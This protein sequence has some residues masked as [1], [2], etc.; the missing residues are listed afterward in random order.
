MRRGIRWPKPRVE[1]GNEAIISS[2]AQ[3][4]RSFNSKPVKKPTWTGGMFWPA[5]LV[6][7]GQGAFRFDMLHDGVSDVWAEDDHGR[8]GWVQNV[9]IGTSGVRV[10][11]RPRD[12]MVKLDGRVVDE[13]GKGM[14]GTVTLCRTDNNQPSELVDGAVGEDGSF[15][16]EAK[17]PSPTDFQF[18]RLVFVSDSGRTAWRT[19]PKNSGTV[20]LQLQP[21]AKVSGVVTD[22][23]GAPLAGAKVQLYSGKQIAYG[24]LI[25]DKVLR[26][27]LP[28]ATTD[29]A[30]RFTLGGLPADADVSVIANKDGY[31]YENAWWLK[32]KSTNV[33]DAGTIALKDGIALSGTVRYED[34]KPAVGAVVSMGWSEN[35]QKATADGNGVYGFR[36]LSHNMFYNEYTDLKAQIGEPADYEGNTRFGGRLQWGDHASGVDIV[37]KRSM[38][39]RLIEWQK[40]TG[41]PT[42][43]KTLAVVGG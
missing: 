7:D 8:A 11:L 21:E 1:L 33:I 18:L 27:L 19:V 40:T 9:K 12:A 31:D 26:A 29:S 42:E 43:S 37:V 25:F 39:A 28:T 17:T 32:T 13:Q 34:G 14:K 6:A 16:L 38:H 30:G 24:E 22:A 23:Q 5:R 2:E 20:Q 36:G 10:V 4:G 35:A 15:K 3:Q 41:T